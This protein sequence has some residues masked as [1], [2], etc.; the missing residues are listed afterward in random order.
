MHRRLILVG[1][2]LLSVTGT[3]RAQFL[4]TGQVNPEILRTDPAIQ[5][6]ATGVAAS[7]RGP[8]DY[9]D[10]GLGPANF[11]LETDVLGSAGTAF[12]LGD[13]GSLTLTFDQP[14]GN[15][16]GPDF[17]V[18]ENGFAFSGL[19]YAE[20]G[21]VEVSS[22]GVDFA[23]LPAIS[24]TG[25]PVASFDGMP[26]SD[27]YNLAGNHVGG[28]GFDLQDLLTALDPLVLAG[29]V[30]LAGITHVRVVDVIGD[31][32]NDATQDFFGQAVADPYPTAFGSGGMDLTGVAVLNAGGVVTTH[33]TSW[34]RVKS[35]Y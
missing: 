28:T 15:G 35:L 32:A 4:D 10:P 9:L 26:A 24:R 25:A 16:P 11:G 2:I 1:A 14:I 29:T 19:V 13:G 7:Q 3:A 23:R 12:S 31:F 33:D 20:I 17:A 18:F 8:Q 22:N 21:F 6:W 30:N 34:G 5:G 27:T